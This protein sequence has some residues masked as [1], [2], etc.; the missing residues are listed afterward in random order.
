MVPS[1]CLRP[2]AVADT[3]VC[4]VV[5]GE[6]LTLTSKVFAAAFTLETSNHLV[7]ASSVERGYVCGVELLSLAQVN[8]RELSSS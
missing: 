4:A 5:S 6:I 1:W 8:V 2:V 3:N 7:L